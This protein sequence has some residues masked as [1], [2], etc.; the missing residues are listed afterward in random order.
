MN[1]YLIIALL[2]LT[3]A[4][5]RSTQTNSVK[6]LNTVPADLL[7]NFTDDYDIKYT[8]TNKLW[9]QHPNIKYHL[10]EYDVKGQYYI[11]K[12]DD[13]NPSEAGL[14]TRI[15]IMHFKNMEPYLWGFCLTRYNATTAAEAIS[16][17]SADRNNP[18]KGCGGFPFSRMKRVN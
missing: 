4:A 5:C 6:K 8:I 14:Y 18:R 10:L 12:N 15:D 1:K 7:G 17:A 13:Q 11:A 9:I 3:T 2:F 16:A